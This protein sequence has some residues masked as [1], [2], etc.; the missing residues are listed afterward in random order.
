MRRLGRLAAGLA[1]TTVLVVTASGC[2]TVHGELE[3]VP[4][5]TKAEAAKALEDFTAAYNKADKAYDP[6]LDEDR[7]TGSLGAINQAGLAARRKNN[8]QGNAEHE[9]LELTDASYTIPKK[10][11][12]P[13]WFLADTDSNRDRDSGKPDTRWLLAF[14]RTGPDAPWKAAYLAVASP[15]EIP[16]FRKDADGWA[17]PVPSADTDAALATPPADLSTTYTD[18]LTDGA[19]DVFAP[20]SMTSGWRDAR[21]NTRRAGFSYQYI[22]QE[23]DS[24]TFA[25]LGLTTEDG[26]ALV[27]FSSKHFERQTAAEGLRP[28]VT[29]DV[30]ALLTGEVK[31]T[32]TKERVSSQLVY[33]PPKGADGGTGGRVRVLNRLPGLVAA[34]GS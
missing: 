9:P 33:V 32:L 8:P 29:A 21:K 14:V 4:G 28:T 25:P 31:S 10:A 11:G 7:V 20:G 18:Y 1:T 22:D 17:E 13:R 6:A 2:V 23:L 24:G 34:Q 15:S 27:F 26:G 3:V 16:K 12:W 5:A 19:P 30:R